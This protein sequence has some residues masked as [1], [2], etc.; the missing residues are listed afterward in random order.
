MT[1]RLDDGSLKIRRKGQGTI[2]QHNGQWRVRIRRDGVERNWCVSSQEAAEALLREELERLDTSQPEW[3]PSPIR[4][5][6]P[7]LR[8]GSTHSGRTVNVWLEGWLDSMAIARPRTH[9]FYTQK[10]A[11]VRS[12]L[13][14]IALVDLEPRDIRLALSEL[15]DSGLSPTMLNHVY[16]TLSSALTAAVKEQRIPSNPCQGIT[17]PKRSDFEG[18]T[19]T[20]EQA[21]RLVTVARGS[22]LGPLLVVALSTGARAGELLALTW[23]DVDL[24]RGLVT[25]NK[26][27][28][29]RANGDHRP[30]PTKTRSARRSIRIAGQALA[31]LHDQR[32]HCAQLQLRA[33]SWEDRNLIFPT[34]D[35][36]YWVPSGSFV[37]EFR[38]LLSRAGCP[39]IRFHDL[40]HTAGLF[41]TRSVGL[42]VTSRMLGHAD[43]SITARYYGHAAQEDFSVAAGAMSAMLGGD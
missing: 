31:A 41:L 37:R 11:H 25:I 34:Q 32:Q 15:R 23:D 9:A 28:Q 21:S 27:A 30:G 1:A 2:Y 42:V 8:P 22:R 43:P 29:W 19:L 24:E 14:D 13:G 36:G 40:R 12:R 33:S 35:G 20:R 5:P 38:S 3:R 6:I 18:K 16:V 10:L 17:A 39:Q 7:G 4:P 26:T